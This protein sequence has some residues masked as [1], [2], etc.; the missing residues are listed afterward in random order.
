M[1]PPDL[2]EGG[3]EEA[4]RGVR[5]NVHR[6][7][8]GP[9]GPPETDAPE[10]IASTGSANRS[11]QDPAFLPDHPS[12]GPGQYRL[13]RDSHG[14][15]GDEDPRSRGV[16]EQR[17]EREEPD[18][19]PR[20]PSLPRIGEEPQCRGTEQERDEIVDVANERTEVQPRRRD[21]G[22]GHEDQ[23]VSSKPVPH[24]GQ[25]KDQQDLA[26]RHE[27]G[28]QRLPVHVAHLANQCAHERG[29]DS[30]AAPKDVERAVGKHEFL[31]RMAD[32]HLG[33]PRVPGHVRARSEATRI[34]D[35]GPDPG[36]RHARRHHENQ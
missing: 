9:P 31:G 16:G 17:E 29:G 19:D 32:E 7:A 12:D 11:C 25:S 23:R 28:G 27:Q 1:N 26:A 5:G 30:V 13:E 18:S 4:L 34:R 22:H 24:G 36:Q 6:V 21:H 14:D 20:R 35:E 33:P 15:D 10:E 2:L 8:E 3:I